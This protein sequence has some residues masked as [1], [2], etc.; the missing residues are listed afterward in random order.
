MTTVPE[1]ESHG[2][3]WLGDL[4]LGSDFTYHFEDSGSNPG[5]RADQDD[6]FFMRHPAG[7]IEIRYPTGVDQDTHLEILEDGMRV[8]TVVF[9]SLDSGARASFD[10]IIDVGDAWMGLRF[11]GDEPLSFRMT[12]GEDDF[13]R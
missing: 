10:L 11:A 12:G 5:R 13:M 2:D 6:N 3:F 4:T 8:A 9:E 1:F 7:T